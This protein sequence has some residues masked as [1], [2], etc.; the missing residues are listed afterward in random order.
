MTCGFKNVAKCAA[1]IKRNWAETFDPWPNLC[2]K[3]ISPKLLFLGIHMPMN[4]L[5]FS[6]H[7]ISQLMYKLTWESSIPRIWDRES[8]QPRNYWIWLE[9]PTGKSH[10]W[11][12]LHNLSTN[13]F[14]TQLWNFPHIDFLVRCCFATDHNQDY[15]HTASGSMMQ[16]VGFPGCTSTLQWPKSY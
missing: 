16:Y 6:C 1:K 11:K 8:W 12:V 15:F 9:Q 4:V 2:L 13:S 7:L 3:K 10:N 5:D 14:S